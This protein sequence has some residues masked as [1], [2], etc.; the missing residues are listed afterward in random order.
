MD[1]FLEA[2]GRDYLHKDTIIQLFTELNTL[3]EWLC[4]RKGGKTLDLVYGLRLCLG[5][6]AENAFMKLEPGTTIP[7]E[8]RDFM[9]KHRREKENL[10]K[11][12]LMKRPC[13]AT[14]VDYNVLMDHYETVFGERP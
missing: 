9:R 11:T 1:Q 10:E 3:D 8:V 7:Q 4:R 5:V 13:N 12:H 14:G 2:D 6:F